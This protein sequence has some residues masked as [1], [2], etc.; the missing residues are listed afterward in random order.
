MKIQLFLAAIAAMFA[1]SFQTATH[2]TNPDLA[3]PWE[4]LGAKKVNYATAGKTQ[5]DQRA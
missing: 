4:L 2:L 5:S 3:R 1:F